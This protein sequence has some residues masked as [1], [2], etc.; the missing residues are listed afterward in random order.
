MRQPSHVGGRTLHGT[1]LIVDGPVIDGEHELAR[2]ATRGRLMGFEQVGTGLSGAAGQGEVIGVGATERVRPEHG[3]GQRH[4]PDG[5]DHHG[6]RGAPPAEPGQ[7]TPLRRI[8][9][10]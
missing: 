6:V 5:D 4:E 2:D 3:T 8:C 10:D 9:H 1:A 7:S